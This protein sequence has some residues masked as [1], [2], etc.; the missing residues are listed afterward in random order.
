MANNKNNKTGNKRKIPTNN[1]NTKKQSTQKGFF[2][3]IKNKLCF[4]KNE[5]TRFILGLILICIALFLL[6]S[7]VSFLFNGKEDA[8]NLYNINNNVENIND[9]HNNGGIFG[10]KAA[11]Y[12]MQ[13][14]F[15]FTAILIPIFIILLAMKLM[16]THTVRISQ[17]FINFTFVMIW[18]SVF[19]A[20]IFPEGL[21]SF[22]PGGLHGINICSYLKKTTGAIGLFIILTVTMLVFCIYLTRKTIEVI[23]K[24]IHVEKPIMN[25]TEN[26]K[27]NLRQNKEKINTTEDV[28]QD[29]N[30]SEKENEEEPLQSIEDEETPTVID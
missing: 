10:L 5:T 3:N 2:T 4:N 12:F 23:R 8:V 1:K 15:G 20:F 21:D 30:F 22:Y 14:G 11:N 24:M 19:L 18:G 26:I 13:E 27:S 25:L 16:K 9:V 28:P 17:Q 7:F 6:I 29:E